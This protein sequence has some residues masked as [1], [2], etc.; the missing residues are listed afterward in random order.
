MSPERKAETER[1]RNLVFQEFGIKIDSDD[2]IFDFL[3][4]ELKVVER[5]ENI[6]TQSKEIHNNLIANQELLVHTAL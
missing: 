4:A 3:R 1:L 2:P 5:L 6:S